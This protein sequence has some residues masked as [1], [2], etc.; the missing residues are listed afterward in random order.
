MDAMR[1]H[2]LLQL[3]APRLEHT[4]APEASLQ[5]S[6]RA[7]CDSFRFKLTRCFSLTLYCTRPPDMVAGMSSGARL[8]V[9]AV[10]VACPRLRSWRR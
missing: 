4:R 8:V 7:C 6:C 5:L 3:R 10:A 1:F 9:L 2:L